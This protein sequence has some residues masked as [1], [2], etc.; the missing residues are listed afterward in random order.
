MENTYKKAAP[1]ITEGTAQ[2]IFHDNHNSNTAEAQ[3]DRILG[4]LRRGAGMST[5]DARHILD[6]M[7][8]AARVLELR[9]N[10]FDIQTVWQRQETP[11]GGRHRVA[12]YYLMSEAGHAR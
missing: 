9:D 12:L 4:F 10:G 7:H 5:I 2:D 11:E 1:L 6:V 8:P 3:R